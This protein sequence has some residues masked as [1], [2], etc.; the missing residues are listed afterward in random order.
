MLRETDDTISGAVWAWLLLDLA[1]LDGDGLG[2]VAGDK[3]AEFGTATFVSE[4]GEALAA[5]VLRPIPS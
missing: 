4:F 3:S 5:L 1:F 2:A